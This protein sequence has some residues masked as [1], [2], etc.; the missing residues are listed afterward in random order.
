MA[1]AGTGRSLEARAEEFGPSTQW[2]PSSPLS[3][4]SSS[5]DN[6]SGTQA[7]ARWPYSTSRE[8]WDNPHR[9]ALGPR[10]RSPLNYERCS[11]PRFEPKRPPVPQ[12]PSFNDEVGAL[13]RRAF[14]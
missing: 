10:G 14:R 5:N 8:G 7:E 3:S 12:R 11:L 13:G 1:P 2:I 4:A 9:T 6:D